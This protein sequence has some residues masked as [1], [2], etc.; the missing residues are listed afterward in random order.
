MKRPKK[1]DK[2]GEGFE[3]TF[4]PDVCEKCNGKCCRGGKRSYLWINEDEIRVLSE[5][6]NIN[7]DEFKKQYLYLFDRRWSVKDLKING[8]YQCV[9]LNGETGKCEVYIARPEQCRTYPFWKRFKKYP[10][11]LFAECIAV[12]KE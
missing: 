4:D 11:E 12:K 6:L 9:F 10:E 8:K 5:Y 7:I 2:W 3:F 1:R